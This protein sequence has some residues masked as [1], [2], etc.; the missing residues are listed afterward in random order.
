MLNYCALFAE[1]ESCFEV[2]ATATNEG[3]TG[4]ACSGDL[5]IRGPNVFTG[6]YW[7]K[8][9]ATAKEFSNDKGGNWFRTGDVAEMSEE[10]VFKIL[11]RKSVDIIKCV[12]S[13]LPATSG[14]A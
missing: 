3:H 12:A 7:R 2:L 10:G 13:L 6:G 14:Q 5:E 8:P 1:D 11:G 4:A 9:E